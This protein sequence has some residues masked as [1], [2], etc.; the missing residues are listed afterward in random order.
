MSSSK[1]VSIVAEPGPTSPSEGIDTRLGRLSVDHSPSSSATRSESLPPSILRNP[2]SQTSSSSSDFP[3]T[4][5]TTSTHSTSSS[6]SHSHSHP[7]RSFIRSI[8][9]HTHDK[10]HHS[11]QH[12]RRSSSHIPAAHVAVPG[13]PVALCELF[14][15]VLFTHPGGMELDEIKRDL[16]PRIVH[17]G[18]MHRVNCREYD[19]EGMWE[20]A[21]FFRTRFDS[22]R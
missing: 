11:H 6:S 4:L 14:L 21:K 10:D 9:P 20:M 7:S 13:T 12:H 3:R 1:R 17:K 5:T 15:Q 22:S 16:G 18:Y 19:V 8:L 2:S